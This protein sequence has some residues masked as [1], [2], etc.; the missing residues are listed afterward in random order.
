MPRVPRLFIVLLLTSGPL[1]AQTY[2]SESLPAE[3]QAAVAPATQ[4]AVSAETKPETAPAPV[5]AAPAAAPRSW[6]DDNFIFKGLLRQETAVRLSSPQNFSKLKEIV[7]LDTKFVFSDHFK[8]RIGGRGWIDGVY[9]LT[10]QYPT[11]VVHNMR[12]EALLRDAYLDVL[13]PSINLRLGLQQIVWGEALGQFFADVVT[14][15]DLRE[16]FLPSFED[17]RLPI[18]AI[19][20]QYSFNSNGTIEIVLSPDRTVDKLAL[21]GADFAF[22]VPTTPGLETVLL[23][24]NRPK[25]NFKNWNAGLRF[26]Y[27]LSGWD[28]AAFYYTSPDHIPALAKTGTLDP[29]TG[30]PLVLLDPIHERVHNLAATFSKGIGQSMIAR[31]EFVFTAHRLFNT[32]TPT[33]NRGLDDKGQLR[34]VLGFDYDIGGHVLMNSE[35]QQEAIVGDTGNIADQKLRSWV[36]LR[37]T[38]HFLDNKLT[39]ELIAIVGLD[40]GDT[41]FGPRLSYNVTDDINLTWGADVFSGPNDQL[42]GQFDGQDRFFMNT[43]WRF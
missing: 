35:F 6:W 22:R 7:K 16:F 15:K 19:D 21:P 36:F 27:L 37:F 26:A 25:T 33:A 30:A 42:Y 24:D 18:W 14:P 8:L 2:P 28:L 5:A 4:P 11:P 41:M 13:F 1:Y 23:P 3:T 17:V 29:F 32:K 9:D 31:G 38:S 40:R 34:Y 39:P 12:A 10:D 20:A 43:E